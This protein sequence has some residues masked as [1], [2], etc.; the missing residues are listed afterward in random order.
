MPLADRT[1][2]CPNPNKTA[3]SPG[4]DTLLSPGF[5]TYA[6][7][8]RLL[9][10]KGLTAWY[11]TSRIGATLYNPLNGTFTPTTLPPRLQSRR[12][13]SGKINSAAHTC[14]HSMTTISADLL[15]RQSQ[16]DSSNPGVRFSV[17]IVNYNGGTMLLECISSAIRETDPASQIIVVDNG[18]RDDSIAS[19]PQEF[20]EVVVI[21]NPCNAGFA[22]AVNQGIKVASA[23]FILLLNNDAQLEPGALC[24]FAGE[25][26][27]LPNL[28]IAGG[29]LRYPDGRLQSAFAPLPSLG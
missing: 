8:E 3:L 17:V 4:C 24:A 6:T 25:F 12:L 10:A 19:M 2:R 28:A 20:S 14:G 15:R 29:Q 5:L 13:T 21:R 27:R 7:I 16:R 1:E 26:D 23:E 18:S 11:D 22:R 9:G